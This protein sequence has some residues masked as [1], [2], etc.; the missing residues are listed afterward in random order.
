MTRITGVQRLEAT[1]HRSTCNG[2]NWHMTW[3]DD[4][5]Q[6]VALCDGAGWPD[7][8]GHT[9]ESYN[10]RV[11]ATSGDAPHPL[12]EHLPGYPDLHNEEGTRRVNS[13]TM[14]DFRRPTISVLGL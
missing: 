10:T 1:I 7:I 2:D 12:F 6:Y 9:S 13:L 8:L 14:L 3:A 5:R 4:D 11:F